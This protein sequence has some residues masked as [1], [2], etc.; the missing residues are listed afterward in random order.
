MEAREDNR[1]A[2]A[3]GGREAA[4]ISVRE[5]SSSVVYPGRKEQDPRRGEI[6]RA[7]PS[8]A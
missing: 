6:E 2:G 8:Q 7:T 3:G 1:G 4:S 5:S